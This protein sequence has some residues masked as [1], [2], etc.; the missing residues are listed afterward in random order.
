MALRDELIRL[1][2]DLRRLGADAYVVGG[3]VRDLLRGEAPAD[4]DV[5]CRDPLVCA[6]SLGG[7]VIRLGKEHLSAWRVVAGPHVF[8]FASILDGDI[9]RDLGRRDFTVNA[10]AVALRSGALL[11]P[12]GGRRDLE[13]RLVRMIDPANFDDDPLRLLK[14]VR[15]GIRLRFAIDPSTVAAIRQRAASIATVAPERVTYELSIIFSSDAFRRAVDLL[16]AIGLDIA[17]FEHEFEVSRFHADDVPL[18]AACALLVD[19]PRSYA[20][21]WRWSTPLLREVQAI[22]QLLDAAGNLRVALYDAGEQTAR[23]FLAAL[24]ACGRDDR[25][26]LPDFTTR[27]LLGGIDIAALTALPP[28]PDLGRVKRALLEAQIRGDVRT[29]VEAE[30]FV[31]ALRA[32]K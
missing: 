18:A 5:A 24:R 23:D 31:R 25:V 29:R 27:T 19:D 11:D 16:H 1:F 17:L 20:R 7:K 3:A 30:T 9:D 26:P 6:Q 12:H 13:R 15:M 10:M 4:V 22:Q 32:A 2:P 21:R 28:G 14:A 8:D